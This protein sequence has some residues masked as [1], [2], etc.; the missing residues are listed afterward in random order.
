MS[1]YIFYKSHLSKNSSGNL[2]FFVDEKYTLTNLKKY[3]IKSDY[4]FIKDILASQ[5]LNRKII[6][7]DLNSKKIF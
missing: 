1:I 6:S 7:F 4:L 5:D 3:L 2:I